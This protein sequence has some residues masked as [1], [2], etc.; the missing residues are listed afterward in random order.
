M[1]EVG[2]DY[3][4]RGGGEEAPDGNE[5]LPIEGVSRDG[6]YEDDCDDRAPRRQDERKAGRREI[7]ERDGDGLPLLRHIDDVIVHCPYEWPNTFRS[8]ALKTE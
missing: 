1:F 5:G 4:A 7:G 8:S 3:D 2:Q 6:A